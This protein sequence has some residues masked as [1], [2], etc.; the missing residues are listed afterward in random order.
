MKSINHGVILE[1]RKRAS[2][3]DHQKPYLENQDEQRL[4]TVNQQRGR[5]HQ[6][7]LISEPAQRDVV[8]NLIQNLRKKMTNIDRNNLQCRKKQPHNMKLICPIFFGLIELSPNP[9]I[10][11]ASRA[12]T[13]GFALIYMSTSRFESKMI[14]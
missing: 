5:Q 14:N 3:S 8:S 2:K 9:V 6:W 4:S 10:F 7:Q 12:R 11:R 1:L 13:A